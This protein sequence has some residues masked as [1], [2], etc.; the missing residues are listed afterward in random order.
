MR[1]KHLLSDPVPLSR[2]FRVQL[3]HC[4]QELL[5]L[6]ETEFC[7]FAFFYVQPGIDVHHTDITCFP[8]DYMW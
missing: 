4:L 1:T 8:R 3:V 2:L 7:L 6:K 5:F